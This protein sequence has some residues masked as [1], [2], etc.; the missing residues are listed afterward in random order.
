[1]IPTTTG[2]ATLVGVIIPEL[3]GKMD[4]LSF[5]VP[6]ATVSVVD[7]VA[8]LNKEVTMEQVNQAFQGRRQGDYPRIM[9]YCEEE[10]VSVD[11]K[12]NP[13]SS[14]IDAPTH[15]GHRQEY[16]QGGRLVR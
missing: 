13:A 8:E 3:K 15:N 1:M 4:G 16:G 10:L 5:R 9:E 2:A 14:I 7:F 11:F 6:T 12:G